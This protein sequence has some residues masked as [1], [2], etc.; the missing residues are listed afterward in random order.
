MHLLNAAEEG[1]PLKARHLLHELADPNGTEAEGWTPLHIAA[2]NGHVAPRRPTARLL[3][4]ISWYF[5]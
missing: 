5:S 3:G 4:G 2:L 1:D